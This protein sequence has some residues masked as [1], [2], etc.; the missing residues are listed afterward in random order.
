MLQ[1]QI[2]LHMTIVR[3]ISTPGV[4]LVTA[5]NT[6]K[7]QRSVYTG[8]CALKEDTGV[9]CVSSTFFKIIIAIS[10]IAEVLMNKMIVNSHH[11][12]HFC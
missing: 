2:A 8:K 1:P 3:I 7:Q 4:F 9:V 10:S 6:A 12:I 11:G 5:R